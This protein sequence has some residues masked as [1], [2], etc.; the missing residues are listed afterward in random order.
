V[1]LVNNARDAV[2]Q[3]AIRWIR[4]EAV[5]AGGSMEISVADSGPGIPEDIRARIMDPF[6]TTKGVG[7]GTG[8]GLSISKAIV[9]DHG[10]SLILDP[11]SR[12]TR[13]VVKLPRK[14]SPK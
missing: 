14:R 4:I 7:R 5:P 3:A 10:G 9:E 2:A 8:L 1:N 13:F 11:S 6:F 12:H